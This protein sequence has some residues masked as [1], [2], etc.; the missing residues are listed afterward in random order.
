MNEYK[1]HTL[2][3][4]IAYKIWVLQ[5]IIC[6]SHMVVS[7]IFS[8][9]WFSSHMESL[10]LWREIWPKCRGTSNLEEQYPLDKRSRDRLRGSEAKKRTDGRTIWPVCGIVSLGFVACKSSCPFRAWLFRS[11]LSEL[12]GL[13]EE[14]DSICR[15]KSLRNSR[16][17]RV[18]GRSSTKINS[19]RLRFVLCRQGL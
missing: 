11:D 7:I 16:N 15:C 12:S 17:S 10:Y 18:L 14:I 8:S 1:K 9:E 19:N 5:Q 3:C 13:D 4:I 2:Q 6:S